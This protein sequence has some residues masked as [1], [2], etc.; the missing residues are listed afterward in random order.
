MRKEEIQKLIDLY[1]EGETESNCN[2]FAHRFA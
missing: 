2:L 1:F